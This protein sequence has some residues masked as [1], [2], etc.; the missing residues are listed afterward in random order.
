MFAHSTSEVRWNGDPKYL[1]SLDQLEDLE[2]S[3]TYVFYSCKKGR[4][5]NLSGGE[6]AERYYEALSKKINALRMGF[7]RTGRVKELREDPDFESKFGCK[8]LAKETGEGDA[9]YV[10]TR[11]EFSA[12]ESNL[13]PNMRE[14]ELKVFVSTVFTLGL[15]IASVYLFKTASQGVDSMDFSTGK[16]VSG[17]LAAIWA[18]KEGIDSRYAWKDFLAKNPDAKMFVAATTFD[19]SFSPDFEPAI[20]S[21][22]LSRLTTSIGQM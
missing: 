22:F 7:A 1:P 18:I 5:E 13:M 3:G 15:V 17:T 19:S 8:L 14:K 16:F 11:T 21:G 6:S 4:S 2:N 10:L 9:Q 12:I 20:Y